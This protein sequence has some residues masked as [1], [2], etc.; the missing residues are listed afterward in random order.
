M[1]FVAQPY[2]SNARSPSMTILFFKAP[3]G[4]CRA[5]PYCSRTFSL[6]TGPTSPLRAPLEAAPPPSLVLHQMESRCPVL[7]SPSWSG[8]ASTPPSEPFSWPAL[9]LLPLD[10]LTLQDFLLQQVSRR[11]STCMLTSGESRRSSRRIVS[12]T[13][14]LREDSAE[15]ELVRCL[16]LVMVGV[17][18]RL[19]HALSGE[20]EKA[21][22]VVGDS[23]D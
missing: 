1:L 5:A 17:Q 9:G 3:S 19:D 18:A 2:P 15:V 22:E 7:P 23:S 20:Q 13:G 21:L 11:S 6:F 4:G 8:A 16:H 14:S 10:H 12:R